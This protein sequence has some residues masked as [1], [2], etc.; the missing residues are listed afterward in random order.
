MKPIFRAELHVM[1]GGIIIYLA[2]SLPR[3]IVQPLQK[4]DRALLCSVPTVHREEGESSRAA[5][6]GVI[7][8]RRF[9]A[10]NFRKKNAAENM[11]V[12]SIV[13][14]KEQIPDHQVR[15]TM[16]TLAF[17]APDLPA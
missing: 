17:T 7:C 8:V 3:H 4:Q 6:A 1:L 12:Q 10:L 11:S 9:C 16:Q 5:L 13:H 15:R 2:L 14:L